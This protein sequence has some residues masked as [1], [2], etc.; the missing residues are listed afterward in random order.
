M[1]FSDATALARLVERGEASPREL[2]E[3][4][5]RQIEAINPQINAVIVPL[6][7]EALKEA[8]TT[9]GHF[10]GVPYVLKDLNV[11]RGV[12]YACGNAALKQAGYVSDHDSH[13]VQSMRRAGFV[14]IGVANTPELGG[15]PTTE[16]RAWG[17]TRNPWN[18]EYSAG[19]SSG[20]SAAAV[21]AD[22]VAVG[23][24]TDSGGSAR[25]PASACG[26]VGLKPT[27]GRISTGPTVR[28]SDELSGHAH[29]G[30]LAR[31]IRDVAA[32]LDAVEGHR[33]GNTYWAPP[34]ARP[35]VAELRAHPRPL[36]VG[37]LVDD[38][39]GTIEM[40]RQCR[41]AVLDTAGTLSELGHMVEQAFPAA[42][43][44]GRVTELFEACIPVS[45]AR[46][47]EALGGLIGR[48]LTAEDVEP[49]TW[50]LA[51]RAPA[52]TGIEYA[53]GV[54]GIRRRAREIQQ[55]WEEDGWDLLLTPTMGRLPARIGEFA[56]R[57]ERGD[58]YEFAVGFTA[59][60]DAYNATGQPAISL[61]LGMSSEGLPIGV[62]LVGA[63]GRDDLLLR[64]AAQ[65]EAAR[66]WAE[67]RPFGLNEPVDNRAGARLPA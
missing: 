2:V 55:W 62:Q 14:L 7:S 35:Y 41:Q 43:A 40:D 25:M 5:I 54:D 24:A 46:E 4:S 52:V 51:Q 59:F 9:T 64:V 17:P 3:R 27:R 26:V 18:V 42:L 15:S 30:I 21:A 37:V 47:L 31:T 23:H 66:P 8:E 38:P 58:L 19:G 32:V 67:A 50:E 65:L 22:M 57:Q 56:R 36:R 33:P 20:G 1:E 63:Y 49:F 53:A 6:F 48:P 28:F 11:A 61:P 34:P 12:P 16:P 39:T 13:F 44:R 60:T 29:E 10:H 45:I